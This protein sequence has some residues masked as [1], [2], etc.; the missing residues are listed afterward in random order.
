MQWFKPLLIKRTLWILPIL[1]IMLE[2]VN[3]I[4]PAPLTDRIL[5]VALAAER[6]YR[7]M[8]T[9]TQSSQDSKSTK[10]YFPIIKNNHPWKPPFGVESNSP[11]TSSTLLNY[12]TDLQIGWVR[13]NGRISWRALQ[14]VED[15]PIQWHLLETFEKELRILNQFNISPIVI[16]DDY[17]RWATQLPTSC[18]AIKP[19][20]LAK[21]AQFVRALVARYKVP[22]FNVHHWEL[23]NEPDVDPRLVGPDS[24]FGCW[25][26]VDDPYYGGRYY[27]EM[28][29]VV[30]ATIRSEDPAAQIWIGGLL[31]NRPETTDSNY[32]R[33][34][35]FL[36]GILEA[37]AAPYFDV[38]AY[39]WYPSYWKARIDYDNAGGS[40]WNDLGGGVIGKARYLRQLM[41]E[42][43]VKK[44]VVLN[45]T[46]FSCPNDT[47]GS[48]A[49]CDSP[50]DQFY[51]VQAD[52]LVRGFTRGLSS[53]VRGL[54]WYTI[55]G[56]GWR[57]GG[58]L[59]GDNNPKPVYTAY[60]QLAQQLFETVYVG[61]I[62]YGS[63][64]EAYAFRKGKTQVHVVWAKEDK[65]FPITVSQSRFVE[66][67]DRDGKS[68][69]PMLL[70]S[71]YQ[72]LVGFE[73]I[74][75][76]LEA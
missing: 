25:G 5:P 47:Y 30:G 2:P 57:Y 7:D 38:V 39:H 18:G 76:I 15:G 26:D 61:T 34:E 29:K 70:G 1:L 52:M 10:L 46:S 19:D 66:A 68:L 27:G 37:G 41:R 71:K 49:W 53:D 74:Y 40:P 17:P 54:I 22:A 72:L 3:A 42:Y 50:D 45:E 31:L 58:L 67:F 21:F 20:K 11:L 6:P 56:P 43:G 32:G 16:I 36:K 51:Q 4:K 35:L 65:V 28:L 13:L 48:Y 62:D 44:P 69:E 55:D 23:G 12:L 9:L 24:V 33:P 73:P 14:P 59:D 75:I 60:Q 8:N 64:L 63:S